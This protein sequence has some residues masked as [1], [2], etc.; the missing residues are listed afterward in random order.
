MGRTTNRFLAFL[1]FVCVTGCQTA[2]NE[3][4]P[5]SDLKRRL[6]G[7]SGPEPV[8]LELDYFADCRIQI[9]TPQEAQSGRC[10]IVITNQNQFLLTVQSPVGGAIMDIY[11][12]SDRIE[13]LDHTEKVFY[14]LENTAVNRRELPSLVDLD[15]GEF[16][17]VFW[18]RRIRGKGADLQLT[19]QAGRLY[20]ISKGTS[21]SDFVAEIQSWLSYEGIDF[22]RT[23]IFKELSRALS[24]KLVITA[25][26]PGLVLE[27]MGFS[28]VPKGYQ[29]Q[30]TIKGALF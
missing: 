26:Q 25:F 8:D 3:C 11:L 23:L 12:D 17:T 10:R 28:K 13:I 16:Q 22:P 4:P 20:Q 24:I 9:R 21:D 6:A 1:V 29:V 14:R 7:F 19:Y 27:K 2:L 30:N 18:G 15:T 5:S